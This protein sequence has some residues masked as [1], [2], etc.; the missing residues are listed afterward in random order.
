MSTINGIQRPCASHDARAYIGD[1]N[2]RGAGHH[3]G[4]NHEPG[5]LDQLGEEMD[6]DELEQGRAEPQQ[7]PKRPDKDQDENEL[8]PVLP[9][10]IKIPGIARDELAVGVAG[11]DQGMGD[12]KPAQNSIPQ[13]G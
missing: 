5:F 3:G 7:R 10:D 9:S 2:G 11:N 13:G 8:H 1:M 6:L 4:G 12:E